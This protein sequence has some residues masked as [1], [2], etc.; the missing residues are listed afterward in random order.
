MCADRLRLAQAVANL[1]ANAA[2]HGGGQIRVSVAVARG[3]VRLEVADDGPGLSRPVAELARTARG[4]RGSRGR[5]LAVALA[6][7]QD[8]GGRLTT[9]PSAAGA[10]V[11]LELPAAA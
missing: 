9:A 11:V 6:A 4:G 7:A 5:G 3:H 2:E 10:R 8:A 1:I